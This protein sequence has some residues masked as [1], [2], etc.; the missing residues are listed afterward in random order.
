MTDPADLG[1]VAR[2][3]G[4][5]PD[6]DQPLGAV[7]RRRGRRDG[8]RRLDVDRARRRRDLHRRRDR[9]AGGDR[10]RHRG[11]RPQR[12]AERRGRQRRRER[13][14]Q[15]GGLVADEVAGQQHQGVGG[16]VADLDRPRAVR[17]GVGERD[18]AGGAVLG[19][20]DRQ[21]RLGARRVGGDRLDRDAQLGGQPDAQRGAIDRAIDAELHRGRRRAGR[22]RNQ[23]QRRE[24]GD[25]AQAVG[26]RGWVPGRGRSVHAGPGLHRDS[27][28]RSAVASRCR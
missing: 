6:A 24:D 9:G 19:H 5:Q 17:A 26:H 10:R 22:S 25:E 3:Q 7:P 28:S 20:R 11:G 27:A 16:V 14:E 13:R 23:Q 18:R 15:L 2:Q 8:D 21:A 12:G 1:E 4:H